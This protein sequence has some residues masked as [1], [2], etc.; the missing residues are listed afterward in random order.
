MNCN[1]TP[2]VTFDY[3]AWVA[4]FPV[5]QNV[6][7]QQATF[8]FQVATLYCA[9]NLRVVR[10]ADTLQTLLWLLTA[11]I[12]WLS[13][14]RDANGVPSSSGILPPPAIVGRI[15]QATEGS[16]TV[17][18]EWAGNIPAAAAWYLQSPW[19]ADFWAATA[20]FRTFRYAPGVR[21]G[22]SLAQR[23]WLYPNGS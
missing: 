10:C 6:N 14:M 11:H 9:N 20:P 21:R 22:L 16:V 12:A 1:A 3:A 18:S 7:Q 19:G 23:P 4:A 17:A 8:Y 15:S 5:F 2:A 13:S